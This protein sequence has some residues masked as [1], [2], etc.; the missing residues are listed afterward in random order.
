MTI[1]PNTAWK[2]KPG[3]GDEYRRLRILDVPDGPHVEIRSFY[4][5]YPDKS[6]QTNGYSAEQ[7]SLR[8]RGKTYL[9]L[10]STLLQNYECITTDWREGALGGSSIDMT[11]AR[12]ILVANAD[13]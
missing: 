5:D 2:F 7:V 10:K 3:K 12:N 4:L 6:E 8:R 1:K 9:I 11:L 13:Y